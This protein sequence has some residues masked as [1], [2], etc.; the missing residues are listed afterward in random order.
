M[1]TNSSF[2]AVMVNWPNRFSVLEILIVIIGIG[3]S[4]FLYLTMTQTSLA[5]ENA[6]SFEKDTSNLLISVSLAN[7][8]FSDLL[9][10]NTD[11][12]LEND[13]YSQLDNADSLCGNIEMGGSNGQ[14]LPPPQS[15]SLADSAPET[16]CKQLK[17]YRTLLQQ[18][19]Q[20]DLDGL[21]DKQRTASETS[22]KQILETIQLFDL[23]A[24]QQLQDAEVKTRQINLG[25]SIG[26]TG[27]FLVISVIV[28]RTRKMMTGQ[29]EK[30]EEEIDLRI[31]INTDLDTERNLVNTLIQNLPDA[32][33]AKDREKRFLI[34]NPALIRALGV[35]HKEELIGKTEAAFHPSDVGAQLLTDESHIIETGEG[36]FNLQEKIMD[37]DTGKPRWWQTTKVPFRNRDGQIIGL[38]GISREI[39]R[40]KETEEALKRANEELTLG[41]AA[42]EKSTHETEYLSEMVDLLQACPSTEEACVVIAD[43]MNKFFPEDS[44]ILY[45]F[46]PSRNILDR[47]ASWGLSLPDPIV[48]KPDDC[49]G[50]RRGKM[51]IV[52]ANPILSSSNE[53]NNFLLC[54]H[55][56]RNEPADYLCVPLMAQGETLGLIHLHHPVEI[57]AG[58][59]E[60]NSQAWYDHPK[61]Q[62]IHSIVD[63]L[64]LALANLRLRASLRQQSIRDPLTGMFNRRYMEETLEREILRAARSDETV[65]VVMIDIDHFKQFN[66]TF[67]HQAGDALLTAL[68]HFFLSHVRGEDVA[69][70]YGGEEFILL[71]PGTSLENT[72][73]RAEE[74]REKVRF[75]NTA[76]QGQTLGSVTLSF[77]ISIFPQ[78]GLNTELLI[79]AADQALYRAKVEGRD[80]I[81]VA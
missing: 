59:P 47:A 44:G 34:V 46:H 17:S 72:V 36:I 13:I 49:W 68:G 53:K 27:I 51:H 50:L 40:Q 54:A 81:V 3:F 38:V 4:G 21:P 75:V 71:L 24:P 11:L 77:G 22:F 8:R 18:R 32:V 66:D 63:S 48:I 73:S 74:L 5:A 12:S 16:L 15:S 58:E 9:D 1:K 19:W 52:E 60:K 10:G 20:D 29:T 23:M 41:I 76:F 31:R 26:L 25:L 35:V 55:I 33:F 57:N 70:R 65:G 79:Q 28:W 64:S 61:R 7:I 80:R 2:L 42:L 30:L 69:C 43:Q 67:G 56:I 39:T 14:F 37:Q 45:L 78:H 62:R 6:R